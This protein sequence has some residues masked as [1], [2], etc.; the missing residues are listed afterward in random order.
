MN[1]LERDPSDPQKQKKEGLNPLLKLVLELGPLLVFFFANAR[2]E[3]LVQKVPALGELGGPIF[4][5]TGLFMA[6]TAI[7]LIASW[8]LTRTLPIMPLV[9]GVVVLIFGALTLYLQD[10]IFIKMKPTIVNT[11]F[12]CV[13][14]GGL[15]FGKSLLGYVF[16]S[17]FSLDAEGWRKLTFRWGL[18]FLFLALVNEVVWRNFSTDAWVTFKVWGIMPITL[19]FTFSQM[20]LIM[21][22]SLE[23]K[24]KG[25]NARK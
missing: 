9:S 10:D 16:D 14:L 25:E 8:L 18:F 13:L 21:R 1:I 2:G 4:V 15:F 3:W 12:G 24:A 19:L 7:A 22:H 17:A 23:E 5:A 6:A 11:L 20:P